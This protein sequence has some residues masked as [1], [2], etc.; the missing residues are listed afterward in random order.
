MGGKRERGRNGALQSPRVGPHQLQN[1]GV[2]VLSACVLALCLPGPMSCRLRVATARGPA[3]CSVLTS[4]G[5]MHVP[6]LCVWCPFLPVS[7]GLRVAT[8]WVPLWSGRGVCHRC[9]SA[10][11][12]KVRVSKTSHIRERVWTSVKKPCGC[13]CSRVSVAGG[14]WGRVV[15]CQV[16]DS[17]VT[18]EAVAYQC[19]AYQC[20]F[21]V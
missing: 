6:R 5:C 21:R 18:L 17:K 1:Q 2:P 11:H 20:K 13:C 7:C 19:I 9:R 10:L 16:A 8:P 12:I 4:L 14:G 15:P 3:K